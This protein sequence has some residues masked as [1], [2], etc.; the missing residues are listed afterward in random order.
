[1]IKKV[2]ALSHTGDIIIN[3]IVGKRYFLPGP[4]LSSH[5]QSITSTNYTVWCPRHTCE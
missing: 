3:P 5:L 4:Q 1:M 2:N